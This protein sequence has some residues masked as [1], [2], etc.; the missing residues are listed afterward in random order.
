M[1]APS[2]N[3]LYLKV[4]ADQKSGNSLAF[5]RTEFRLSARVLAH[6]EASL[7]KILFQ[8]LFKAMERFISLSLYKVNPYIL[9]TYQLKIP[10]SF[11]KPSWVPYHMVAPSHSNLLLNT[12]KRNIFC[13]FQYLLKPQLIRSSPPD[14]KRNMINS[15]QLIAKPLWFSI[16]C[17]LNHRNF[18]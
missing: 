1:F 13:C 8:V 3:T 4:S 18:V 10:L 6:L 9:A 15:K 16:K 11:W 5:D 7:W 2:N 14:L 12:F 17:H